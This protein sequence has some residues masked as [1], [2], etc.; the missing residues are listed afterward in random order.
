MREYELNIEVRVEFGIKLLTLVAVMEDDDS[1][2]EWARHE[3]SVE[4]GYR[5]FLS[6]ENGYVIA[7]FE[8]G[9][10]DES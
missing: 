5:A 3:L 4:S 6:D 2:F 7:E 8:K 9:G 10:K 1:A